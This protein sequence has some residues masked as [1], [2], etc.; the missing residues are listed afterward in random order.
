[1]VTHRGEGD[2]EA[3]DRQRKD[4]ISHATVERGEETSPVTLACRVASRP[5]G[6]ASD[7]TALSHLCGNESINSTRGEEKCLAV[8]KPFLQPESFKNAA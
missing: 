1:M 6:S 2:T 7:S 5:C 4:E 3:P 8:H